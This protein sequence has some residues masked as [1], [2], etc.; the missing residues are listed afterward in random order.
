MMQ[1]PVEISCGF[2][3][4]VALKFHDAGFLDLP[5]LIIRCVG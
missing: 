3:V 1:G 2:L 5:A 4:K